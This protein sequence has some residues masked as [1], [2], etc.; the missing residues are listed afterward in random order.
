LAVAARRALSPFPTATAL[1]GSSW[2]SGAPG[3]AS[4][5]RSI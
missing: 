3:C 1:A 4:R 5:K 2:C